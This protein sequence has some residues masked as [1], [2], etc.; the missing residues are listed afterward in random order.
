GTSGNH[1]FHFSAR[2]LTPR[3]INRTG[4][5][6]RIFL[7][8]SHGP[9]YVCRTREG[10]CSRK[11]IQYSTY[12]GLPAGSSGRPLLAGVSHKRESLQSIVGLAYPGKSQ[13]GKR[14]VP[15]IQVG[16]IPSRARLPLCCDSSRF[17]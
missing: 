15:A 14:E 9:E 16:C 3:R 6:L 4:G 17:P 7:H 12:S 13:D 10:A 5:S 2:C 1:E 8:R 11:E